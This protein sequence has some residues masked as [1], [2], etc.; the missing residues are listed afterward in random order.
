MIKVVEAS[1]GHL[2]TTG[3]GTGKL[4]CKKITIIIFIGKNENFFSLWR[5]KYLNISSQDFDFVKTSL[6]P[7]FE[8]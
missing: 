1:F 3:M 4:E 8:L 2:E 5:L 6:T 7:F